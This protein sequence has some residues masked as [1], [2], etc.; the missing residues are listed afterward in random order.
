MNP[1]NVLITTGEITKTGTLATNVHKP[2]GEANLY[3]RFGYGPL[4]VFNNTREIVSGSMDADPIN[5][6]HTSQKSTKEGL[7][8]ISKDNLDHTKQ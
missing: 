6:T 2:A 3:V 5:M 7:K 1:I 8:N 4:T